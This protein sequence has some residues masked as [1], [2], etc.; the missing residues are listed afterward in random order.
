M[1]Q[2]HR[3]ASRWTFAMEHRNAFAMPDERLRD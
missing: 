1:Q 2:R 3:C